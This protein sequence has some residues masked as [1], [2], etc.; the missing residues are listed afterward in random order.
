MPY[1]P[2]NTHVKG[3][4][5]KDHYKW[6]NAVEVACLLIVMKEALAISIINNEE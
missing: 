2:T 4:V 3:I 6:A 1:W 5:V